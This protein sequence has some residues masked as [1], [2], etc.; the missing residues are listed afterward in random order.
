MLKHLDE[1]TLEELLALF[2][3]IPEAGLLSKHTVVVLIS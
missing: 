2:D 3:Y 1:E